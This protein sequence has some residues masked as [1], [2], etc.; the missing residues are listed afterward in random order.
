[1]LFIGI[2]TVVVIAIVDVMV[3]YVLSFRF[4]SAITNMATDITCQQ[5]LCSPAAIENNMVRRP[6]M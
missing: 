3:T 5:Y 4:S 6:E 1:M 2:V